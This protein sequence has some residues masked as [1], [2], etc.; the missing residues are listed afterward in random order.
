M[1]KKH[2]SSQAEK[3]AGQSEMAADAESTGMAEALA[4]VEHPP[5]SPQEI[6]DLKEQAARA[7]ENWD[8]FVRLNADF[9]NFKK[10]AAR[11][12]LEAI[13]FANEGLVLKLLP[14]ADNFEMALAAARNAGEGSAKSLETGVAMI[15]QQL[16]N[17]LA[18]A[19]LEE[20]DATGQDFDPTLH[21][22]VSQQEST[23]VPEGH[24]LQQLRKGYRFQG[25]LLRPA[26]VV[27]AKKP[28]TNTDDVSVDAE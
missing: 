10:R 20:V 28:A 1:S 22:A 16:R 13:K 19:G 15:Q 26:T 25:K 8:R 12:R 27:V 11:E 7:D 14:V 21:E 5:L 9:E 23:D 18:E 3:P 6:E 24:V 17:V 2:Q 4:P